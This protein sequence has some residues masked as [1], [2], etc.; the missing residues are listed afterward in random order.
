MVVR[1][2]ARRNY[3]HAFQIDG[4][5][6]RG[7]SVGTEDA[8]DRVP[9]LW[10]EHNPIEPVAVHELDS[11]SVSWQLSPQGNVGRH[12]QQQNPVPKVRSHINLDAAIARM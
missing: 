1:L 4:L 5:V 9:S 10:P 6:T 3:E 2:A 12:R 11:V 8:I 7:W